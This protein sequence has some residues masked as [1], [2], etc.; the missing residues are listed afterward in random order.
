[1]PRTPT[2]HM[3]SLVRVS[4]ALAA[5]GMVVGGLVLA[6]PPAGADTPGCA[7]TWEFAKVTTGMHKWKVHQIFDTAGWFDDGFAGGYTR[8]Y[9]SCDGH[10]IAYVSYEV[11]TDNVA[12][13][14]E[15]RW[16]AAANV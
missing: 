16:V 3:T 7:A 14:I 4:G 5:T 15:K 10:H 1:M 9:Q 11:G 2:S 13:V 12:R 6:A 8:G